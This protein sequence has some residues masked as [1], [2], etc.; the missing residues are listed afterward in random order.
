M[1]K[2]KGCSR[3]CQDFTEWSQDSPSNCTDFTA[4]LIFIWAFMHE[5]SRLDD[6]VLLSL[7]DKKHCAQIDICKLVSDANGE[8]FERPDS[9]LSLSSLL[10]HA[11]WDWDMLCVARLKGT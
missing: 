1:A 11:Q 9:V 3:T 10:V 6:C 2:F 8:M 7:L 5:K 4:H